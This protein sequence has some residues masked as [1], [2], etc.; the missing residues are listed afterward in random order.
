MVRP[1]LINH[2]KPLFQLVPT[3]IGLGCLVT[4]SVMLEA[5]TPYIVWVL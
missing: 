1:D 3:E 4:E 2:F 5:K